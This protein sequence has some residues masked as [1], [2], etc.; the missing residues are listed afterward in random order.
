MDWFNQYTE[1]CW[2]FSVK[3]F[4]NLRLVYVFLNNSI[5]KS[6]LINDNQSQDV[7]IGLKN[8]GGADISWIIMTNS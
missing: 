4:K 8:G 2:N 3:K 6:T 5:F 1:L 7:T